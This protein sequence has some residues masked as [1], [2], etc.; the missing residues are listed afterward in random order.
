MNILLGRFGS[1]PGQ[2]TFGEMV[3]GDFTCKTIEREWL[4]NKGFV[5]CIPAGE[6]QLIPHERPS[7]ELVYSVVNE[8][9]GIYEWPHKDAKRDLI[10]IHTANTMDQLAGCIAPGDRF[11]GLA[12]KFGIYNS[13][14]TMAELKNIL[15]TESHTLHIQ[16]RKL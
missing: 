13:S 15:G 12:G 6:Y 1:I 11:G 14:S 7:G 4:D 16:W 8:D 5:S 9:M 3:I 2:G 10:L